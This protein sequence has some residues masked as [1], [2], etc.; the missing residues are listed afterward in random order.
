MKP[1][2]IIFK[3]TNIGNGKFQTS[4]N[5]VSN[6]IVDLINRNPTQPSSILRQLAI[7]EFQEAPAAKKVLTSNAYFFI[8]RIS[9]V[10]IAITYLP[11]EKELA[12]QF[13][14]QWRFVQCSEPYRLI[15]YL[16][17]NKV[18]VYSERTKVIHTIKLDKTI[19]VVV[20]ED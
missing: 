3:I 4:K 14:T 5:E 13:Y 1:L 18:V 19:S 8:D 10:E 11:Q 9:D 17:E 12:E 6:L 20:N 16:D 15:Q 2:S 7:K